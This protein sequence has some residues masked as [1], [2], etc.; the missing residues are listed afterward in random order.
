MN[1]SLA[2]KDP[3]VLGRIVTYGHFSSAGN[4][5]QKENGLLNMALIALLAGT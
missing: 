5:F 4:A 3:F 2:V 1:I